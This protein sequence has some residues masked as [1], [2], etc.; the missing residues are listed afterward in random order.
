MLTT[1]PT[2]GESDRPV[3][4]AFRPPDSGREKSM[5]CKNFRPQHHLVVTQ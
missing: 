3:A 5:Y 2:P 4:R 1:S